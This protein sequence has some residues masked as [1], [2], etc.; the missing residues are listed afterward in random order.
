MKKKL[1]LAMRTDANQES[2][3]VNE[4]FNAVEEMAVY[5]EHDRH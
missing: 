2:T 5:T 3:A 1:L 4:T